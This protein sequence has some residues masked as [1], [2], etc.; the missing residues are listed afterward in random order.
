[1]KGLLYIGVTSGLFGVILECESGGEVG[2]I[3]GCC[4]GLWSLM[5][6]KVRV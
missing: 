4:S 1:M 2:M 5:G 6:A 3:V